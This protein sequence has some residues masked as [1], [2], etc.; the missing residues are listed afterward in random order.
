MYPVTQIIVGGSIQN[1]YFFLNSVIMYYKLIY[2]S[3]AG[4][5]WWKGPCVKSTR[6][7]YW[8]LLHPG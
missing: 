2:N 1:V 8:A 5:E 7:H 4:N 6:S 3:Q